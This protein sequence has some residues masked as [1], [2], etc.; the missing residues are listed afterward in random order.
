M[1]ILL[2][3]PLDNLVVGNL[4]RRSTA[5]VVTDELLLLT[6]PTSDESPQPL[7]QYSSLLKKS[8]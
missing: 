3:H 4:V 7:P 6:L 5:L 8:K 1:Q 2:L